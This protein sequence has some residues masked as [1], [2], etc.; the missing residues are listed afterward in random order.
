MRRLTSIRF[1][2]V[3]ATTAAAAAS[4]ALVPATTAS[5]STGA[6]AS[7]STCTAGTGPYQ[8]QVEKYLGRTV[9]GRNSESDCL[10]IQ[11]FQRRYEIR[12]AAGYAGPLTYSVVKRFTLAKS[13]LDKCV[14]RSKVA[15]VDLTSQVMWVT[16]D[17]RRTSGLQPIRSGRDGYETRTGVFEVYY[18]NIDHVSSIYG[19]AMPY[20]MFFSGGMAFHASDRY[21][22][23]NPGSHGCVHLNLRAVRRMWDRL[24]NGT[25]VHVFGRKPGT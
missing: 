20:A 4:I 10:A 12:P 18:R 15:C 8:R 24:P 5:A 6:A 9:D 22:Y 17:G 2:T 1:A 13:R 23:D 11:R 14:T 19:S 25:A 7:S 3:A 16:E 21:L